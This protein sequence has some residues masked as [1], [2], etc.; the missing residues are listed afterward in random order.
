MITDY[1]YRFK[2]CRPR[3]IRGRFA[4]ASRYQ[5]NRSLLLHTWT[6]TPMTLEEIPP[7]DDALASRDSQDWAGLPNPFPE[8]EM[9]EGTGE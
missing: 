5:T 4:A 2:S 3:L 9:V 7:R 8:L 6:K 1:H